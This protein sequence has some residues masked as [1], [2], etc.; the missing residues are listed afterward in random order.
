LSR[1]PKRPFV[2]RQLAIALGRDGQEAE[3][4]LALAEE[5][6]LL[7]KPAEARYHAGK[8][9]RLLP[10]GSPGWLQAKDIIAAVD[11]QRSE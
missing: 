8:A 3:S 11:N 6:I 1:E 10:T 2:W 4:A 9:E 7:N 5:A